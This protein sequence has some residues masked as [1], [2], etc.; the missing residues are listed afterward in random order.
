M[1]EQLDSSSRFLSDDDI[2]KI[3]RM[4]YGNELNVVRQCLLGL[5][6]HAEVAGQITEAV[7]FRRLLFAFESGTFSLSSD[8]SNDDGIEE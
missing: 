8:N 1:R 6:V 5:S 3:I 7:R 2:Q 4:C